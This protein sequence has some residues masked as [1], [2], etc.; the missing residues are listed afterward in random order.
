MELG[1]LGEVLIYWLS[2][3]GKLFLGSLLLVIKCGNGLWS[4]SY[5]LCVTCENAAWLGLIYLRYFTEIL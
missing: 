4:S 1:I 2:V 3:F 5:R